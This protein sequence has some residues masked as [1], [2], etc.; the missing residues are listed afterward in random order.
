MDT[1]TNTINSEDV[2]H[3]AA[4]E[5]ISI[6]MGVQVLSTIPANALS[7]RQERAMRMLQESAN[8]LVK[9]IDALKYQDSDN[10]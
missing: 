5:A 1:S 9:L 10:E 6:A 2:A 7:P 4:N 8:R 3:E